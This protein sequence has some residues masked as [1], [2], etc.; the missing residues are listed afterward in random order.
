VLARLGGQEEAEDVTQEAFVKAFT[1]LDQY[2]GGGAF[3][4]WLYR[5]AL[6]GCA[7]HLRRRQRR[8]PALSLADP[9]L[10]EPDREPEAAGPDADPARAAARRELARA[11]QAA[12]AALPEP[13]RL[14]VLLHDLQGLT[15]RE[16]GVRLGCPE[17]TVKSRLHRARRRLREDL[18]A[19]A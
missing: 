5:I 10:Q 7:D 14:P 4:T 11:V 3:Y 17:G 8:L 18:A 6:N 15:E 9:L 19:W 16:V 12:V 2:R 1:R 13:L